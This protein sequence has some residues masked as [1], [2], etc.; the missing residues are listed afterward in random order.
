MGLARLVDLPPELL[1][2]ILS[3]VPG[4]SILNLWK[5][6]NRRL[7]TTMANGGVTVARFVDVAKLSTSR[8]PKALP[9]F[10]H[11]RVL[12]L[13]VSSSIGLPAP[14]LNTELKKLPPSLQELTLSC[15]E[16]EECL[17]EPAQYDLQALFDTSSRSPV[18]PYRLWDLTSSFPDLMKLHIDANIHW[19]T[20]D[21]VPAL[22]QTLQYL[23]LSHHSHVTA[24][25]ASKLPR[26][27]QTLGV[28]QRFAPSPEDASRL[29]PNLTRLHLS[30]SAKL[31]E[32]VFKALPDTI[33]RLDTSLFY[34]TDEMIKCFPQS[35]RQ[36]AFYYNTHITSKFFDNQPPMLTRLRLHSAY[37]CILDEEMTA[38]L[39]R[40]LIELRTDVRV[41]W[42]KLTPTSIPPRLSILEVDGFT[43]TGDTWKHLPDSL[44]L[45]SVGQILR[46]DLPSA[47][48]PK[49]SKLELK[50]D[51]N[52]KHV[53]FNFLPQTLLEIAI[54][55]HTNPD[56]FV[57]N[58]PT[59]LTR[60]SIRTDIN[61]RNKD[62]PLLPRHLQHLSLQ[63]VTLIDGSSFGDLPPRLLSLAIILAE[64]FI[65][66]HASSLPST[67]QTLNLMRLAKVEPEAIKFLPRG[68]L[69]LHLPSV[70]TLSGQVFSDLPPKLQ[71]LRA[72]S[73]TEVRDEDIGNLPR[74]VVSISLRGCKSFTKNAERYLPPHLYSLALGVRIDL[75]ALADVARVRTDMDVCY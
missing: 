56:S 35:L 54:S 70:T 41:I 60:L 31:S 30:G 51:L 72:D 58:L 68:L 15:R 73:L 69:C 46:E 17:F 67:L 1:S 4:F 21:D 36:L 75:F 6:G 32:Q 37:S 55:Y 33:T 66:A 74:S 57:P 43:Y 25:S 34:I 26:G 40:T 64:P 9:H 14:L 62:V 20:D 7:M 18:S 3:Q 53:S 59:F 12:A 48:P 52:S 39:P 16:A 10:R 23:H 71:T 42:S 27:L 2:D 11:L 49:L 13:E 8:Y 22:P 19:L 63:G 44:L 45:L 28:G 24:E 47:L 5:S 65:P 29:P 50:L 38:K 61:L